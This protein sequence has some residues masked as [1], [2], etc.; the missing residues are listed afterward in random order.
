MS[1][2]AGSGG[3]GTADHGVYPGSWKPVQ[4]EK[5]N[6]HVNTAGVRCDCAGTGKRFSAFQ[7]RD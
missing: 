3:A 6:V 4:H 7:C 5:R 2:Q 1:M